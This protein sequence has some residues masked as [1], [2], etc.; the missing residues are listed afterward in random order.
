MDIGLQ[1]QQLSVLP[2]L[3]IGVTLASFKHSGKYPLIKHL[4]IMF[5]SIFDK[6]C[7]PS[8]YI[9]GEILSGSSQLDDENALIILKISSELVGF[10]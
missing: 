4:L 6:T 1:L 3:K 8:L 9:L 2:S 10:N 7:T 5:G